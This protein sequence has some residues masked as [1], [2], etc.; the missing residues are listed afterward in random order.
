MAVVSFKTLMGVAAA[1]TPVVKEFTIFN[2][3][4]WTDTNGGC[5]LQWTVP[6]SVQMVKFEILSGGGPGGSSG[7]DHDVPMGG[8]GGNYAMIQLFASDSEFTAGS[9]QYTLCAAGTS[10][11]SCCCHCCSACR[12]GC[13]S[14]V[15]GDGLTNFCTVGGRGGSNS[16]DKMSSCYNC[17][18]A[19][20][21]NLGT[22]NENWITNATNPG[23]CG[24]PETPTEKS[25]G[26]TGTTGHSYHG[27]DCCSHVFT[28]A[29]GPT[30]PFAV[31]YTGQGS[32]WCTGAYSCCSSHSMFPGGAGVGVGH[33]TSSA[34]WGHWGAGGLVKVTYQ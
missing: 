13:T 7:G 17:G 22:Y 21:C 5:C 30:G 14:Y 34:C 25:M 32:S 33:A 23:F 26:Y 20:Q 12:D 15:T 2:R 3:N 28:T 6:A 24:I 10:N 29:G 9:S 31:S 4:H 1:P 11:C 16:W 18:L 27:Y 19:T 8:Q